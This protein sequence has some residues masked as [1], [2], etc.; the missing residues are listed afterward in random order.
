MAL[1]ELDL[2]RLPSQKSFPESINLAALLACPCIAATVCA[3]T[4]AQKRLCLQAAH[5]DPDLIDSEFHLPRRL[6]G[7][8]LG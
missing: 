8:K 7:N 3:Q 2:L 6:T 4:R 5:P 1:H